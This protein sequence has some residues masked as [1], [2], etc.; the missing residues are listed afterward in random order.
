MSATPDRPLAN[1]GAT[2]DPGPTLRA[3]GVPDVSHTR[4]NGLSLEDVKDKLINTLEKHNAFLEQLV[5]KL[6]K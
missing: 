5:L 6:M 4:L 1:V 2:P 3:G